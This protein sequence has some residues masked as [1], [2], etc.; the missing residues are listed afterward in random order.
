MKRRSDLTNV[1]AGWAP[2]DAFGA[3]RRVR[4]RQVAVSIKVRVT[5]GCFHREHSPRAYELIDA[6][7]KQIDLGLEALGFEEHESG[8]EVL[9]YVTLT[10]AGIALATSATN[11]VVAIL[12]ARSEGVRKGD[13][14]SDPLEVVVRRFDDEGQVQDETAF[15]IGC[16]DPVR[17]AE[18]EKQLVEALGKLLRGE[19]SR[20]KPTN[21]RPQTTAAAKRKRR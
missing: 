20:S 17:R 7:L 6:E 4:R 9:A 21:Q 2:K 16:T 19:P 3:S 13:R 10:A 8:P 15:R 1:L 14:P 5:S 18:V 11:L 12:K